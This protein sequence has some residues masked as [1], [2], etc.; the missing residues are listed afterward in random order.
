MT[1][2]MIRFGKRTRLSGLAGG[3][4]VAIGAL[5]PTAASAQIYATAYDGVDTDFFFQVTPNG[6]GAAASG[7]GHVLLGPTGPDSDPLP[8]TAMAGI[9]AAQGDQRQQ[10][11]HVR[12]LFRHRAAARRNGWLHVQ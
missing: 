9:N 3:A 11:R 12:L 8:L 1:N 10:G 4:L 2:I 7:F 6:S 5:L